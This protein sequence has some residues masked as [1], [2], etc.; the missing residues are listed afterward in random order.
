MPLTEVGLSVLVAIA[1]SKLA[2]LEADSIEILVPD[3]H[4]APGGQALAL[5]ALA[6]AAA[7]P[8]AAGPPAAAGLAA[9]APALLLSH[10]GSGSFGQLGPQLPALRALQLRW[11]P[12]SCLPLWQLAPGLTSLVVWGGA[13]NAGL[14]RY[15]TVQLQ[16]ESLLLMLQFLLS[17]VRSAVSLQSCYS[18]CRAITS[19]CS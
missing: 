4:A 2:I 9:A 8:A 16:F 18:S 7:V 1:G 6:A 19:I 10:A 12:S 13:N 5:G 11:L 17:S 15:A 14:T 3:A